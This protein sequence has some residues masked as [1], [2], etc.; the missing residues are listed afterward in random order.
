MGVYK[1]LAAGRHARAGLALRVTLSACLALLA[2]SARAQEMKQET[3][4]ET[5]Q[6]SKSAADSTPATQSASQPGFIDAVGRWVQDGAGQF[7]SN[8]QGAQDRLEQLGRQ[9][10]ETTKSVT[11]AVVTLPN[12]RLVTAQER[13]L[14]APNGAPDCNAAATTLCR[15]KGFQLG[16]IVDTKTEQKCSGRFLLEGRP[17]NSSDCATEIF[18]TKAVCQ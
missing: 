12:A 4:P 5:K 1:H 14:A 6:E 16:K 3:K 10:Q 13:C 18:V 11:G 17:P 2:I 15:S 8:M 9:A 7:K